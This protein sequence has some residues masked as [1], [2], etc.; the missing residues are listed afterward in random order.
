MTSRK[1]TAI[2]ICVA[3]LAVG[4]GASTS[5]A[6]A[7]GQNAPKNYPCQ[8]NPHLPTCSKSPTAIMAQGSVSAAS[9]STRAAGGGVATLP[10][11]G[12]GA[13]PAPWRDLPAVL[14][15]LFLAVFGALLRRRSWQSSSLP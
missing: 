14:A 12:G 7:A 13:T 3:A 15:A 8:I 2:C 5:S 11:T 9:S 10:T 4:G 1:F 6:L